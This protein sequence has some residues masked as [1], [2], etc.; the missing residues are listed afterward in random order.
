MVG[1]ERERGKVRDVV[2]KWLVFHLR[3]KICVVPRWQ[4]IRITGITSAW[5]G[6]ENVNGGVTKYVRGETDDVPS[7]A[8]KSRL[9]LKSTR[10]PR[11]KLG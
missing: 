4:E 1:V 6:E 2:S 9:A 11:K 8:N 5:P 10:L 7:G 3:S